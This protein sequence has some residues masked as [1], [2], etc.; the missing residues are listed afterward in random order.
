MDA[1]YEEDE[2]IFTHPR[3]PHH[4]I[5]ILRSSRHVEVL[6]NGV[7]VADSRRPT[8]LFETGLPTRFYLPLEDVRTALLRPSEKTTG[9]PYKGAASYWSLEVDDERF[10]NLVWT[11]REPF[12]ESAPIAGLAAFYNETVELRVDGVVQE[13]P[14]TTFWRTNPHERLGS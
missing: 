8:L 10:E 5:D 14:V 7:T 6:V 9:C 4:R 11:Y 3:D 12:R 13:R 1:W 2:E